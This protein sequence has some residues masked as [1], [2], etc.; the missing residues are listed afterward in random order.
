MMAAGELTCEELV[1]LITDYLEGAMPP[2]DRDR[3]EDHLA[4]CEGCRTYLAQVQRTISTAGSL[5]GESI[6]APARARL[7]EAF[8]SWRG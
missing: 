2:A 7:L 8:R 1:E 4:H 3:F 5:S 6:P